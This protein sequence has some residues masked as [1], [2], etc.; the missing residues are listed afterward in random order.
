[1][2]RILVIPDLH[3]PVAHPG[4]MDFIDWVAQENQPDSVVF[5]GDRSSS[6]QASTPCTLLTAQVGRGYSPLLT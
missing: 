1:M 5:I 4:S 2:P 3:E 6:V